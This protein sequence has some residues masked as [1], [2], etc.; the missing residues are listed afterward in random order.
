MEI[1]AKISCGEFVVELSWEQQLY[2]IEEGW[3]G[4]KES[5]NCDKVE[6]KVSAVA[7]WNPG[8][9]VQICHRL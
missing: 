1:D 3:M 2:R 9:V 5:L 4:Q 6:T 8:M 7:M